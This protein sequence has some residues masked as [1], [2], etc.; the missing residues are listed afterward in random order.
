MHDLTY[1]V[2]TGVAVFVFGLSANFKDDSFILSVVY[3][4]LAGYVLVI[5]AKL[6]RRFAPW[7]IGYRL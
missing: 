6:L 2:F 4:V 5:V 7:M 3:A 1:S